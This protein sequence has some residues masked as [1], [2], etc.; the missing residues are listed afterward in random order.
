MLPRMQLASTWRRALALAALATALGQAGPAAAADC[1]V[2]YDESF[3][4]S[5]KR[6]FGAD[7]PK[8]S[9]HLSSMAE[10]QAELQRVFDDPQYR[11]DTALHRTTCGC[12]GDDGDAGGTSHQAGA[13]WQAPAGASF[14]QQLVGTAIQ[15]L[16]GALFAFIDAP[17]GPDGE[18]LRQQ[19][20]RQWDEEEAARKAADARRRQ[21]A[22]QQAAQAASGQ[23]SGRPGLAAAAG[24]GAVH[25]GMGTVPAL[26]RTSGA[27]SEAEWAEA[28]AW[29][30]RIDLLRGKGTL[31]AAEARELAALEARRNARWSR[32]VA[33]PGLTQRDRDALKL[34][35]HLADDGGAVGSMDALLETR[36]AAAADPARAPPTVL[37]SAV[38]ASA[39]F[40][41]L[42]AVE[43]AGEGGAELVGTVRSGAG[44]V[45]LEYGDVLCAA[46]VGLAIKDGKYEEASG[47]TISWV[48]GK[49]ATK[50]PALGPG[51]VMVQGAAAVT[52]TVVRRE[53][54]K[55]VEQTDRLVPGLLPPGGTG[56]DW[57]KEMKSELTLPQ[58]FVAEGV[59][60]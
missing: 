22:F 38:E 10:C 3:R 36:G 9:G 25:L 39:T 56:E 41:L 7:L 50:V 15:Q 49:L 59:G 23:L 51:T 18:A 26:L 24:D 35:L 1:Y 27:V 55:L 13:G 14:Q 21:V 46:Q 45:V 47:P 31:T 4:Q 12:D 33:V 53:F 57:W 6:M 52:S 28:R 34:K 60:L 48:L 30:T 16:L 43:A 29:Q 5:M 37:T 2:V 20:Q 19:V 40:G 54:E 44:K 32:A 8:R 58:R 17:P 42:A 11:H